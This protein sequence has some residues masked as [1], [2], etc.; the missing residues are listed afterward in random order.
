MGQSLRPP[1]AISGDLHRDRRA[2]WWGSYGSEGYKVIRCCPT[3][4]GQHHRNQPTAANRQ[5]GQP[6]FPVN[7]NGFGESYVTKWIH[8]SRKKMLRMTVKLGSPHI[9]SAIT[10]GSYP[11]SNLPL[12]VREE[13]YACRLRVAVEIAKGMCRRF[14]TVESTVWKE[15]NL[16][17]GY[18]GALRNCPV[19]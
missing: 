11:V 19:H 1:T 5:S 6:R 7:E 10:T 3:A 9:T 16:N 12:R 4:Y 14:Y 17:G 13:H 8:R 15:E 2:L 18:H